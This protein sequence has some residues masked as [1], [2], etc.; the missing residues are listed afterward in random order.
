LWIPHQRKNATIRATPW[1]RAYLHS[2][3]RGRVTLV[4][5]GESS[6][7]LIFPARK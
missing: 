4:R 7:A 1:Y 6:F 5:R 2:R 3:R